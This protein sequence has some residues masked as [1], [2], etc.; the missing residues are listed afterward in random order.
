MQEVSKGGRTVLFVSHNMEAVL[1]LCTRSILLA[2][3]SLF[4][5]GEPGKVTAIYFEDQIS[6]A[7]EVDLR[8][9]GRPLQGNGV[10]QLVSASPVTEQ[11][12]WSYPF[13]QPQ[14]LKLQVEAKQAIDKVELGIGLFSA[15]GFEVASWSSSYARSLLTLKAGLNT[16][17]IHLNNLKLLPGRYYLGLGLR[18]ERGFEDYIAEA[19]WFEVVISDESAQANAHTMLGTFVLNAEARVVG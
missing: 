9:K 1:K 10:V 12:I 11:Q 2:K 13:G 16:V 4:A 8:S 5:T 6:S 17:Q 3:G 15:R 19:V 18:S 14:A 7:G